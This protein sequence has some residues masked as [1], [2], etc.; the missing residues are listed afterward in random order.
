MVE[1]GTVCLG[2]TQGH[3]KAELSNS[4]KSSTLNLGLA[5]KVSCWGSGSGGSGSADDWSGLLMI[6]IMIALTHLKHAM[7]HTY[8]ISN[9]SAI[10]SALGRVSSRI[11]SDSHLVLISSF[12]QMRAAHAARI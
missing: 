1:H 12:L 4:G 3:M 9:E 7:S 11:A 6:A 8:P 10:G 2:R 5:P